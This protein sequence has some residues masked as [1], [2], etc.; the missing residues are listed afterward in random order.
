MFYDQA[1]QAQTAAATT[2]TTIVTADANF[3]NDLV[4]LIINQSAAGTVTIRN[5]T[6]GGT[7]LSVIF[8]AAGFQVIPFSVPLAGAGQNKNWTAQAS[9]GTATVTAVYVKGS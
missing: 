3:R 4:A 9:A 6:G 5:T 1:S 2:E 7:V 8:A